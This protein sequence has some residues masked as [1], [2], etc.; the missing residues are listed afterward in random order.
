MSNSQSN[1]VH[2]NLLKR[3]G[4]EHRSRAVIHKAHSTSPEC[5]LCTNDTG[6]C[7]KCW[8]KIWDVFTQSVQSRSHLFALPEYQ[9]VGCTSRVYASGRCD[10]VWTGF[11]SGSE[12][13]SSSRSKW[14]T[15]SLTAI[16]PIFICHMFPCA[17]PSS[18]RSGPTNSVG[19]CM[20]PQRKPT[21]WTFIYWRCVLAFP[22]TIL[23]HMSL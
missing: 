4:N 13:H 15:F 16:F 20:N 18:L 22:H 23:S 14:S 5:S 1:H 3:D 6:F 17:S 11:T 8:H 2:F 12:M 10:H 21:K 9:L 19:K 7:S